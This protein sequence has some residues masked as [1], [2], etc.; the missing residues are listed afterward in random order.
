MLL[1]ESWLTHTDDLSTLKIAGYII[2]SKPRTNGQQS[3]RDNV[4]MPP[5]ENSSYSI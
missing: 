2:Q 4:C 5:T 1:T 3:W